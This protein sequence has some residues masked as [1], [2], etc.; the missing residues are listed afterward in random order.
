MAKRKPS[1][2]RKKSMKAKKLAKFPDCIGTYP[3]PGCQEATKDEIGDDCPGCPHYTQTKR[4][5]K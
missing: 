1:P 3:D 4:R 2:F 5:T